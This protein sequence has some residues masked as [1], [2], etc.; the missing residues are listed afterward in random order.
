MEDVVKAMVDNWRRQITLNEQS[1]AA[2]KQ[3]YGIYHNQVDVTQETIISLE[4]NIRDM[5]K[6]IERFE[7]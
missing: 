5:R 1:L 6:L 3:G 4:A 7:G 2:L